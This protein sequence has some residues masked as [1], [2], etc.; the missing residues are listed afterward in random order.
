MKKVKQIKQLQRTLDETRQKHK[1]FTEVVSKD[2]NTDLKEKKIIELASKNTNLQLK[3][4]KLK[5]KI[6]ELEK[7]INENSNNS[8]TNQHQLNLKKKSDNQ[9]SLIN[10]NVN[11]NIKEK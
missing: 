7:K 4:T 9:I 1:E 5:D 3:N 11:N 6:V 10:N 8:N 2:A